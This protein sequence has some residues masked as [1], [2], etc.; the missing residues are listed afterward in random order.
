MP[1]RK[2]LTQTSKPT[3]ELK[4]QRVYVGPTIPSLKRYTVFIGDLPPYVQELINKY[5]ALK[6][7]FVPIH[8][9]AEA[10]REI[11]RKGS[12]LNYFLIQFIKQRSQ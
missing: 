11:V 9:I 3:E 4:T 8:K 2:S 1:K 7:L 6:G 10:R 12:I 5:S